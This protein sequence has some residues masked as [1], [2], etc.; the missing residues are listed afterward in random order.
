MQGALFAELAG[1]IANG[2]IRVVDLT[3][4]LRPSKPIIQLPPTGAVLVTP[5]LKVEKGSSW[6]LRIL[7]L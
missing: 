5:P 4:T 1:S 2:S 3:Q 6:R 7:A